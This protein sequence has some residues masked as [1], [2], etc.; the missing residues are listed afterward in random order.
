MKSDIGNRPFV[1]G[2]DMGLRA[3]VETTKRSCP[4]NYQKV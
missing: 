2:A 4:L 3:L 1:T